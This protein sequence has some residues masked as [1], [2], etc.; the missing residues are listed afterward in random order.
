MEVRFL[1]PYASVLQ[2]K[3]NRTNHIAGKLLSSWTIDLLTSNPLSCCW[4][5]S[6][7]HCKVKWFEGNIAPESVEFIIADE[8]NVVDDDDD[9]KVC[10]HF[11]IS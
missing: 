10:F 6:N 11:F 7:R 4:V 5:V 2:Q 8:S 9:G 3:T 1:P